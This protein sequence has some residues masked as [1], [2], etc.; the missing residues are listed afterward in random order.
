[1]P[2]YRD[3]ETTQAIVA[4]LNDRLAAIEDTSTRIDTVAFA[5]QAAFELAV[6]AEE[7]RVGR[8]DDQAAVE[9]ALTRIAHALQ[10]TADRHPQGG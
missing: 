4:A 2:V 9:Q 10:D 8:R 6:E 7:E 1:V 3:A 5:L